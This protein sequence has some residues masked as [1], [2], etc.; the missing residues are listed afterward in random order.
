[1]FLLNILVAGYV[2]IPSLFAQEISNKIVWDMS[3]SVGTTMHMVGSH[4]LAITILS[5]FGLFFN[6][7]TFSVVFMHQLIYKTTFLVVSV[8]PNLARHQY[9]RVP[10]GM[11]CFFL[12][13]L[14]LL[15]F[16]IPWEYYFKKIGF[17][18][19]TSYLS[20]HI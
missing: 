6:P 18:K 3:G 9:D 8:I 20:N 19:L 2:A 14:I 5:A 10:I 13:W 16:A 7:L 4:W 1:M 17:I 12:A 11:S 15:P